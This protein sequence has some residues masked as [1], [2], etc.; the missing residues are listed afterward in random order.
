MIEGF[1]QMKKKRLRLAFLVAFE[2]GGEV[3]KI[4]KGLFLRGH[5][6]PE[7]APKIYPRQILLSLTRRAVLRHGHTTASA[8]QPSNAECGQSPYRDI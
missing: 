5:P 7:C 4:L 2:F 6:E 3:G 8:F 1:E